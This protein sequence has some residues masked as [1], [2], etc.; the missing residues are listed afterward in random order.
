[1]GTHLPLTTPP[2]MATSSGMLAGS[3]G[4]VKEF[5]GDG[6][7]CADL[8]PRAVPVRGSGPV[9]LAPIVDPGGGVGRSDLQGFW[10]GWAVAQGAESL[11]AI[12][13]PRW[14]RPQSST[15]A[16][17]IGQI[18]HACSFVVHQTASAAG[19]AGSRPSATRTDT[20][21]RSAVR[22]QIG[23]TSGTFLGQLSAALCSSSL[24]VSDALAGAGGGRRA[25]HGDGM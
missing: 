17:L 2:C 7:T 20:S 5:V 19:L 4:N 16:R 3:F 21:G 24:G 13:P 1:M 22:S 25:L 15:P 9:G 12:L 14:T 18:A 10:G 23:T 11:A 8:P 6:S